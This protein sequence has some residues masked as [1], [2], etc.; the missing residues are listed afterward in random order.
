MVL[1]PLRRLPLHRNRLP[2]P[3][4]V[5]LLLRP[6]LHQVVEVLLLLPLLQQLVAQSRSLPL[7]LAEALPRL[8][9]LLRQQAAAEQL[10]TLQL[11][12]GTSGAQAW[13]S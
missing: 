3:P 10:P 12:L 8:P 5:D 4:V 6:L 11:Y 2:P 1:P 9:L 13:A 7:L